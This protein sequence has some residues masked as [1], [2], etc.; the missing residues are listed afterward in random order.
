MQL[1]KDKRINAIVFRVDSGGG[2]AIASDQIW[3]AVKKAREAGKKV[4]VSMGSMAASGGYYVSA[5]A[6]MIVATR[7]TVTG[8]IGVFGGKFA[9]AEALREFGINPDI[10]Q[11][12]R[13]IRLGLFHRKADGRPAREALGVTEGHL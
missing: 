3:S 7:S 11:R 2:S 5:G 9:I 6:D 4:V 10:G 13:R 12:R 8:S 1:A